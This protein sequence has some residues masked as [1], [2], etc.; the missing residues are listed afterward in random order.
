MWKS[1]KALDLMTSI[2]FQRIAQNLASDLRVPKG[3]LDVELWEP[4][5]T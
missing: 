4:T 1:I 3:R 2:E 5:Q